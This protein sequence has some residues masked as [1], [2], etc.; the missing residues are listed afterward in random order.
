MQTW[1]IAIIGG[2]GTSAEGLRGSPVMNGD[3]Q[4]L[5]GQAKDFSAYVRQTAA[6]GIWS[7]QS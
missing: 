4:I 7:A 2:L 1:T 6:T 3:S 5:G